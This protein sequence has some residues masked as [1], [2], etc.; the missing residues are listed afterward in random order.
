MSNSDRI[1]QQLPYVLR[2]THFDFLGDRYEGKVRDSYRG[3]KCR[4]LVT[5]DRL[6]CFDRVV[7]YVP[8]KGQVLTE[9]AVHWFRQTDHIVRNHLIE[10]PDPNVMAVRD[11]TMLPVEVVV[12]AYL[13]GSAW[14][15]YDAG[16]PISGVVLPEGLTKHGKLPEVIVTPSTKAA[17]GSHDMPISESEIVGQNLVAKNIWEEARAK[18]LA[19][20]DYGQ[21]RAAE[22]GL[23]LVD[24]KYEFGMHEGGLI[25]ADEIHTLDSSRYWVNESYHERVRRGQ[26]PIMLDKEPTRQWLLDQGY[27]GDGPIPHFSDEHLALISEHYIQAF[28]WITGEKFVPFEGDPLPRIAGNLREFEEAFGA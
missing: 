23:I 6:S 11:C 25:L 3:R 27:Q 26:E 17:T 22:R 13:T 18:A 2:E 5:S 1:Q 4:Y 7:A 9:L 20:F 8:F 28:E 15:D 16:K 14:R 21:K 19:L 12:R 24:T 10:S